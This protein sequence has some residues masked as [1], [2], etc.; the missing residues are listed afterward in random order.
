M[1]SQLL[2]ALALFGQLDP[3][4][5]L[6][7]SYVEATDYGIVPDWNSSASNSKIIDAL[8]NQVVIIPGSTVTTTTKEIHFKRAP[9][10]SYPFA[11]PIAPQRNI[12]TLSGDG[13]TFSAISGQVAYPTIHAG[14]NRNPN[15]PLTAANFVDL[16]G[17]IDVSIAAGPDGKGYGFNPAGNTTLLG[18]GVTGA[19]GLLNGRWANTQQL[20]IS[21]KLKFGGATSA[22]PM[23]GVEAN[24]RGY[25]WFVRYQSNGIMFRFN[26]AEGTSRW[27]LV[28]T[29]VPWAAAGWLDLDIQLD[30]KARTV[31]AW[32]GAT[33][34]AINGAGLGADWTT[35]TSISFANNDWMNFRIAGEGPSVVCS[36]YQSCQD[37]QGNW[38]PGSQYP[39][40]TYG[41]L[42]IKKGLTWVNG[43]V[44][45]PRKRIDGAAETDYGRFFFQDANTIWMYWPGYDP[46]DVIQYRYL[47]FAG[48]D[49]AGQCMIWADPAIGTEAGGVCDGLVIKD[50]SVV[51]GGIR[52]A[53]ILLGWQQHV[54]LQNIYAIGGSWGIGAM[55]V[56]VQYPYAIDHLAVSGMESAVWLF[57]CTGYMNDVDVIQ[58][59][60]CQFRFA[61][62]VM[63]LT[64]W[65]VRGNIDMFSQGPESIF[66]AHRAG[67]NGGEYKATS[68]GWDYE[69]GPWPTRGIVIEDHD[70]NAPTLRTSVGL[71]NVGGQIP[72]GCVG[73]DLLSL[74]PLQ[75]PN[76]PDG[77]LG[78]ILTYAGLMMEGQG[79]LAVIRTDTSGY[80]KIQGFQEGLQPWRISVPANPALAVPSKVT[81]AATKPF[82]IEEQQLPWPLPKVYHVKKA[83]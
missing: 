76:A 41:A 39:D 2:L 36:D 11:R 78:G 14:F 57:G 42:N 17:I 70:W 16:T 33:Q 5:P 81:P 63:N 73:V 67:N 55:G 3:T 66:Y 23:F 8:I 64:N 20:T 46:N 58:G 44:G 65:M 34:V 24:N 25:P 48:G 28:T 27:F 72:A 31:S 69:G 61:S 43:A 12:I 45:S 18:C 6:P 38:M 71:N 62:S 77:R 68:G 54:K 22:G 60:R 7:S 82:R 51:S 40:T 56:G 32:A 26:T 59:G 74:G 1:L 10:Q 35:A 53:A 47:P 80:W 79:K 75:L 50:L 52:G 15:G 49:S 9:L 30:L 37:P 13:P 21:T 4:Q 83:A 29:P 19:F